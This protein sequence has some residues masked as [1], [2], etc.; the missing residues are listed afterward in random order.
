MVKGFGCFVV[1]GC[2]VWGGLVRIGRVRYDVVG[3]GGVEG[4]GEDEGGADYDEWDW[5]FA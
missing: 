3:A 4:T 2:E 1:D 5:E